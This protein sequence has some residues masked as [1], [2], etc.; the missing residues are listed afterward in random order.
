[1]DIGVQ[2]DAGSEYQICK[3]FTVGL[4]GLFH[5]AGNQRNSVINFGT[6]GPYDRGRPGIQP[7]SIPLD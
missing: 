2:F 3:I 5:L 4:D 1:L 6:I 7:Y